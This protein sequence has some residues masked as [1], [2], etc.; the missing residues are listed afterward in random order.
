MITPDLQSAIDEYF[1][2]VADWARV[3]TEMIEFYV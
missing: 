1:N 2:A 3:A